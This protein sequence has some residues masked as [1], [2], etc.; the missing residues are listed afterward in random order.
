MSKIDDRAIELFEKDLYSLQMI[1]DFFNC[2]RQAVKKWLNKKGIDT[3]YHA[4]IVECSECGKSFKKSRSNF[5]IRRKH[6]CSIKCYHKAL[7]NSEY[8]YNRQGMREARKMVSYFFPLSENNI[9]HHIDGDNLNNDPVNLIVF[10]NQSDH[11]RWHRMG[12]GESGIEPLW[13]G[14]TLRSKG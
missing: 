9:V 8:Y 12:L 10:K 11:I 1:G 13:R 14:D 7:E 3:S 4:P 6:Y 2:S 5:R